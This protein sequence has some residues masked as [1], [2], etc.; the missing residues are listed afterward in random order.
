MARFLKILLGVG[1]LFAIIVATAWASL[2]LWHR[3][4]ETFWLNGAASA[5]FAI[6]GVATAAAWFGA[7]RR[8]ALLLFGLGFA[9]VSL[10][11]GAIRPPAIADWA[12]DVARQVT[13]SVEG[14]ILTL[15]SVRNFDW[16]RDDDFTERWETRSYD[17]SKLRTL[18]LFMSYWAG[19]EMAH[20][21]VSFGFEGGERLA[22]SVEVRRRRGGAFSP[23]ADLFKSNALVIVAADE[24]DVVRVRSNVRGEDV[25]IYRLR[26]PPDQTRAILLEYVS[27]ANA[28]A[29][30][31]KFY[32]SLTTNCT[33]TVVKMA[34]AAG[35]ALPFDWRLIVNGY[36][37]DYLYEQGALDVRLPLARVRELAH[38]ADR[39]RSAN[40]SP[41]F[42]ELIR[43]GAPSP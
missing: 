9:A 4:P 2:A 23:V 38:I 13:G 14:D 37:P 18:D 17:L 8:G 33:T 3:A 11:W 16:R 26:T 12:P 24:R 20:T 31:P 5:A 28:L 42:S 6:L 36:L 39:A 19:P 10:W 29:A 22:W 30:R 41:E 34:R 21:I 43:V 25:Q 35:G 40:A 15:E 7:K 1:A 27:D 32:N